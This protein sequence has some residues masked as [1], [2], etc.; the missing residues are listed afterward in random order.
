[1]L[2]EATEKKAGGPE[3]SSNM[4]EVVGIKVGLEYIRQ[5]HVDKLKILKQKQDMF[6][7]TNSN[8]VYRYA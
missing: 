8:C 1:V 5:Q 4:R 7:R 6:Q 3:G 2:K